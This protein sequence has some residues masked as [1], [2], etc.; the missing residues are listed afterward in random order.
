M[1]PS[2]LK[3]LGM[4]ALI[5]LTLQTFALSAKNAR[6]EI[7]ASQ[8]IPLE[9]KKS[10]VRKEI[11]KQ[12]NDNLCIPASQGLEFIVHSLDDGTEDLVKWTAMKYLARPLWN[13]GFGHSLPLA[14]YVGANI[15]GNW[16]GNIP[17]SYI[18]KPIK[19]YVI[20]KRSLS[21]S[22]LI[23][24]CVTKRVNTD[25]I[26]NATNS[27]S[28]SFDLVEPIVNDMIEDSIKFVLLEVVHGF[29][30]A[31]A[32]TGQAFISSRI[33]SLNLPGGLTPLNP[34][35]NDYGPYAKKLVLNI[36]SGGAWLIKWAALLSLYTRYNDI[37]DYMGDLMPSTLSSA[38]FQMAAVATFEAL[39]LGRMMYRARRP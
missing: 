15:L 1:G 38:S 22:S 26:N 19:R 2:T 24:R 28:G 5:A 27:S 39:W 11:E 16:C 31:V 7:K 10:P 8:G 30:S 18:S 36:H 32:E 33:N 14:I 9:I 35:L 23:F 34:C 25:E 4:S 17:E 12:L 21:N 20:A 3:T 29:S 13:S 6:N 37:S